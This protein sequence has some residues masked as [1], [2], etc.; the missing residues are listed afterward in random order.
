M[1]TPELA[2]FLLNVLDNVTLAVA[3]PNFEEA[4]L[5]SINAKKVL[6]EI[7]DGKNV[8]ENKQA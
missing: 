7:A 5:L 6:Q 4:A 3:A 8:K 1:I 2:V